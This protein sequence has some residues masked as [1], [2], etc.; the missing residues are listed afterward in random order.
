MVRYVNVVVEE[1]TE[2]ARQRQRL[3][4]LSTASQRLGTSLEL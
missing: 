1:I 2:R 4:Y 3:E